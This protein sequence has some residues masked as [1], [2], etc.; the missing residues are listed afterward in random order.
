MVDAA[1]LDMAGEG[2]GGPSPAGAATMGRGG[3]DRTAR[4]CLPRAAGE[5]WAVPSRRQARGPRRFVEPN[6][7]SEAAAIF[8]CGF[9]PRGHHGANTM[10]T[11]DELLRDYCRTGSQAAF[12]ELV[13][14]HVDF[15]YATAWRVLNG[16]HHLA[17]DVAQATFAE[18]ARQAAKLATHPALRGWLHTTAY[19]HAVRS[20]RTQRRRAARE[21]QVAVMNED[22]ADDGPDWELLRPV[23]DE[24]LQQLSEPDRESILLRFGGAKR[25][26]ELGA[27]LGIGENAARMRVERALERLRALLARR[28]ITSSV[29]ALAL[30]L[31]QQAAATA[32]SGLAARIAAA[33]GTGAGATALAGW[34]L[35]QIGLA[36]C[37]LAAAAA[38]VVFVA[39]RRTERSSAVAPSPPVAGVVAPSTAATPA[40]ARPADGQDG[41]SRPAS[42][43]SVRRVIAVHALAE[44]GD[45]LPQLIAEP[46]ITW[47]EAFDSAALGGQIVVGF[48]VDAAGA[49]L[50]PYIVESAAPELDAAALAVAATLQFTGGRKGGRAVHTRMSLTLHLGPEGTPPEVNP[51]LR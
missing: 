39:P 1:S 25:F 43:R 5:P 7:A 37:G 18:L 26:A 51:L 27:R 16:D 46:E 35:V 24:T 42:G 50:S 2:K 31:E 13:Q 34:S 19:H 10:P 45:L 21:E 11:D 20:V 22:S 36:G 15:V 3:R 44:P 8:L 30:V 9:R 32:P 49:I 33:A 47:A 4:F 12:A 48:E 17:E 40:E 41:T 28:G 14:R 6:P 23:L 38:A 29:A